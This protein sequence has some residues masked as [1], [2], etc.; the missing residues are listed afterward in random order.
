MKRAFIAILLLVSGLEA[1]GVKKAFIVKA[2]PLRKGSISEYVHVYGRVIAKN[3]GYVISPMPGKLI[4]YTKKQGSFFKKDEPVAYV[5]RNIPGVKTKPLVIKA[6]FDGILAIT[7][8]HEGDMV[9]QTKPIAL[10][11]SKDFYIEASVSSALIGKIKEGKSCL[12][13]A[14]G[15]KGKGI[16][17]SVSFG[18]DPQMGM[19]KIRVRVTEK[20]NLIPGEI[21]SLSIATKTSSNVFIVPLESVVKREGKTVVFVEENGR[22]KMIPVKPGIVSGDR[23]EVYSPDL[24]EK[25]MVI[26][27][28]AFGLSDGDK[29]EVQGK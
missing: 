9:A 19:G 2:E 28:G 20:K 10:F 18:V 22:A 3:T 24:K 7:Y 15:K 21:V 14:E 8:A 26:T 17:E 23:I 4:K 16:V 5:D 6:P 1:E 13:G 29:V 12:I 27:L 25:D 11:Y